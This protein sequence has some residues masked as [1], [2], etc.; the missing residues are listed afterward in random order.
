MTQQSPSIIIVD[1]DPDDRDFFCAGM[2]RV[3]PHIK[4]YTFQ[5][6]DQLLRYLN[7]GA[8]PALP[9]C[10]VLDYK[11]PP[12]TAPQLLVATGSGT[13]Y[14]QIP[15]IV[16]ST[17]HRKT[18]MAECLSLGALRF[19]IK[20]FTEDQLDELLRSLDILCHQWSRHDLHDLY[21]EL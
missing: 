18:E 21:P 2:Q 6:G 4:V 8:A 15:K 14:H 9:R 3:Y 16:W 1:D 17:S 11:M 19:V 7:D 5:N 10:I 13:R 20:P 12:L